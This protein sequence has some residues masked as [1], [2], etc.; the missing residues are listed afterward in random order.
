MAE[1]TVL[2]TGATGG[3]GPAVVTLLRDA[4]WRVVA[5]HR[6]GSRDRVPEGVEPV[7][8]ELTDPGAARRAVAAAAGEA[9]APLRAV[10]NLVGGF[11]GGQP[12]AG[13]PIEAFEAMFAVNL[14]P[15]YLVTAAAL[16]ALTAAGGGSIVC[17]SSRAALQPFKG[18]A[19]YA[20]AKAALLAFARVVALEGADDGV[21]CNTIVPALIDTPANRAAGMAGGVE[22]AEVAR[23]VAWLCG[24]ESAAVT[25]AELPV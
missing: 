15:V 4:G 9:G 8:A 12:V 6:A 1:R 14:R 7:E 11:A 2:V 25:G 24:D 13:T 3:L 16:P 17:V 23:V 22:P 10:A 20:A 5:T 19:G 18:A 21:R